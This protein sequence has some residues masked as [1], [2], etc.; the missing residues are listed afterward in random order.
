MTLLLPFMLQLG[1]TLPSAWCPEAFPYFRV[2]AAGVLVATS[3]DANSYCF[4]ESVEDNISQGRACPVTNN[5]ASV[6]VRN[7]NV[8]GDGSAK[9]LGCINTAVGTADLG[10]TGACPVDLPVP[11]PSATTDYTFFVAARLAVAT[12]PTI[13]VGNI[14]ECRIKDDT[15]SCGTLMPLRKY[16]VQAPEGCIALAAGMTACLQTGYVGTVGS[17][18]FPLYAP[19]SA[20][21]GAP[22]LEQCIAAP[23]ASFATLSCNN[24]VPAATWTVPYSRAGLN[25][26][27]P[28]DGVEGASLENC[29]RANTACPL[30]A[31]LMSSSM[32][33]L[34]CRSPTTCP[35][36]YVPVCYA[37]NGV[38]VQTT[39]A[40]ANG[41]T[42]MGCLGAGAAP[43][44]CNA[45]TGVSSLTNYPF[46]APDLAFKFVVNVDTSQTANLLACAH[47]GTAATC[48]VAAPF[49][50]R[51]YPQGKAWT[52]NVIA[53]WQHPCV[54]IAA[55]ESDWPS[56]CGLSHKPCH[57]HNVTIL[58]HIHVTACHK[59]CRNGC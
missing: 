45:L 27:I 18:I 15:R 28:A 20:T 17:Y 11:N 4:F 47:M 3:A 44:A 41:Q 24:I 58:G 35:S 8:A 31:P 2:P 9:I 48:Q 39:G 25:V 55:G 12:A 14:I 19:T 36:G 23:G 43:T 51:A 5:I 1:C 46:A 16:N 54:K 7:S 50:V 56:C 21:N 59:L 53:N 37:D 6:A 13:A 52:V 10:S 34:A 30:G 32:R 33:I 49:T 26:P 40:C 29:I 57:H 42:T 38:T 22:K